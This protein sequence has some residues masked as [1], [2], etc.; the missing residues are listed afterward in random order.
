MDNVQFNQFLGE[1]Y[2]DFN[3]Y[4]NYIPLFNRSFVSPVANFAR[5][6][7]KFHLGDSMFIDN[8]WCYQLHFEPK[9]SG[10]ATFEGEMWIHDTTYA[11]K[12]FK[13]SI[14]PGVNIN[15]VQDLYME[16]HFDMVAKEVWMLT[17]EKMIIDLKVT[18]N[19]N[20]YGFYGRKYSSRKNIE[21]NQN[22]PDGFFKTESTVVFQ[23]SATTRSDAY[24]AA[25]RHTD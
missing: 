9:R 15:Y 1:M 13:A 11:V 24:W 22:Y 21:V 6:F 14:S 7:Y 20:L 19:S 25:H 12:M 16:H 23:D 17:E 4:D 10:E 8:Q 2:F 18:K 3:V 5:S